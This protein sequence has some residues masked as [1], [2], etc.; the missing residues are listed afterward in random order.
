MLMA[1]GVEVLRLRRPSLTPPRY[2]VLDALAG[3][4]AGEDLALD[5]LDP[6]LALLVRGRLEVP[7]LARQRHDDELEGILLFWKTTK[8]NT[9]LKLQLPELSTP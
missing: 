1:A 8:T 7:R 5:G 9:G 4:Q 6:Q 3:L 2:L